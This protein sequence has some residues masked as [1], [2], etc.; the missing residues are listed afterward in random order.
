VIR[1]TG[2]IA[3]EQT[4]VLQLLQ[5]IFMASRCGLENKKNPF[6]TTRYDLVT[7]P[8]ANANI[9]QIYRKPLVL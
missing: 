9:E 6:S 5:E 7:Y 1:Y 8:K 4:E 3:R 2:A